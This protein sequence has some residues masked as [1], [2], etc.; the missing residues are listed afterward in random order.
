M[1]PEA[2]EEQYAAHNK[3]LRQMLDESTTVLIDIAQCIVNAFKNGNKLLL[4]GNGGSA[5]DAQHI[6]AEFINRFRRERAAFPAIAL[7][8]DSSILTSIGNDSSFDLIFARQ[9]DAL[10]TR[11]DIVAALSTSGSSS[12]VLRALDSAGIKGATRIGFTG[13]T[14]RSSMVVGC[15]LCLVVPSNDTARIQECHEFAWHLICGMV[16]EALCSTGNRA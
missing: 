4:F 7:T 14:G 3:A 6:A 13:S 16:E 1:N 8:T 10:A 2:V 11:G 9:V 5:A 15:D 12:N